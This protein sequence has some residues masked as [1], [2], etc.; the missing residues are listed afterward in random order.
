VRDLYNS[1]KAI[2]PKVEVGISPFGIWRP[3]NPRQ[4]R[5]FDAYA[6]I[7]ADSRLWLREGWVDYLAPQLYWPIEK[8]EQSFPAL[9]R[10]WSRQDNLGRGIVAGMSINRPAT[11]AEIGRMLEIIRRERQSVGFIL[12]SAHTILQNPDGFDDVLLKAIG[13]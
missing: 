7:Y 8:R 6:R 9:L 1:V 3:R 2:R 4:I 12:F 11:R 5:G 10:W 13:D